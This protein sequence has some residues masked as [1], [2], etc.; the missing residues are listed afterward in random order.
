[1]IS[2]KRVLRKTLLESLSRYR[3][4]D[5]LSESDFLAKMA[6]FP[7]HLRRLADTYESA[8]ADL[9]IEEKPGIEGYTQWAETYDNEPDNPVI[10]GE[11]LVFDLL[12]KPLRRSTV[13]DVGAGT[14]RHSI[15]LAQSG[16][17]VTAVEPN[18]EMLNR[19][20]KKA[21][22][23][24]LSIEFFHRE[25]YAPI[26]D[27]R[28]FDLVLCCLVLSHVED[29]ARSFNALAERVITD[30]HLAVTDFHPFNLLAGMRTSYVYGKNKYNVP[31][32]IHL[33]S[34]YVNHAEESGL[35]LKS[36]RECGNIRGFPGMPA[37]LAMVFHKNRG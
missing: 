34:E 36:Y 23:K 28:Q 13:L 20:K 24:G 3:L 30:G 7:D 5:E 18:A 1:M 37:T 6:D 31:N 4:Y 2:Q 27:R 26:S 16:S 10:A 25:V 21:H 8:P 19:A 12:V 32:Y 35:T 22:A 15:P 33:P 11:E 9:A 17:K 14:G 29:F